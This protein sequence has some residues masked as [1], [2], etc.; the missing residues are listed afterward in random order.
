MEVHGSK[1]VERF[2]EREEDVKVN[3]MLAM[4]SL[5]ETSLETKVESITSELRS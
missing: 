1:I 4:K 2:K 3:I 5:L